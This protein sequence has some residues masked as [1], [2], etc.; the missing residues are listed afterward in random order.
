MENETERIIEKNKCIQTERIGIDGENTPIIQS[1]LPKAPN[2]III[3]SDKVANKM[4]KLAKDTHNRDSEFGFVLLGN[5]LKGNGI[6]IKAIYEDNPESNIQRR[7]MEYSRPTQNL[8]GEVAR[9]KTQFDTL[10]ICHTHPDKGMWYSNFSLGDINGMIKDY[11]NNAHFQGKDI[12]YGM[13]TGD[14]KFITAFY[15]PNKEN[16]Y[17]FGRIVVG[18]QQT[19]KVIE[20]NEYAEKHFKLSINQGDEGGR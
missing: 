14:G 7:R 19:R 8:I 17:K 20:W 16:I 15:D 18:N 2:S 11:K 3:I 12:A 4:I 5:V 1:C 9:G 13:L 10:I 6:V